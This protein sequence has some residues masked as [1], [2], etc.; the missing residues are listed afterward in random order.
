[1]CKRCQ[2]RVERLLGLEFAL[3]SDEDI[4][5]EAIE[6]GPARRAIGTDATEFQPISLADVFG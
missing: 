4:G 5:I 6:V 3:Y 1:M 2:Y